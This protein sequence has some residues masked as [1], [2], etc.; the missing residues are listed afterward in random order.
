MKK[1]I[2]ILMLGAFLATTVTAVMAQEKPKKECKQDSSKC[3]KHDH[4][5]HKDGDH[6]SCCSKK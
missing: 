2:V 1:T 5:S 3:N 6:K 4:K